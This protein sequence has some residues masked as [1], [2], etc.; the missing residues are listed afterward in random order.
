MESEIKKMKDEEVILELLKAK[1]LFSNFFRY[2]FHHEND[3]AGKTICLFVN[4]N[5]LFAWGCADSEEV[6]SSE[7]LHELY[8]E[9]KKD[10][11]YGVDFWCCKKRD[12]QPQKVI[13][14]IWKKNSVWNDDLEKLRPNNS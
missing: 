3:I 6:S 13:K 12:L 5:D 14:D 7:E 8:E 10:P 11:Q 1:I 4:C 2:S 9:Y